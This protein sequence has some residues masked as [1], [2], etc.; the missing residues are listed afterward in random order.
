MVP[1]LLL[2]VALAAWTDETSLVVIGPP[3]SCMSS[4][5]KLL[6]CQGLAVTIASDSATDP[7][8]RYDFAAPSGSNPERLVVRVAGWD[9]LPLA[10]SLLRTGSDVRV[11][12]LRRNN[13]RWRKSM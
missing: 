11:V 9:C 7:C 13:L 3:R 4:F 1:L 10:R 6:N 12:G 2:Q 5:V 8:R